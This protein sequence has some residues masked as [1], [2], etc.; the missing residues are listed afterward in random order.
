MSAFWTFF[1]I[2]TAAY[3]V[4]YA[5][6]I[7][8]DLHR[9]GKAGRHTSGQVFV[10]EDGSPVEATRSVEQT[11]GGFRVSGEEEKL[12]AILSA[13]LNPSSSPAPAGE[14]KEEEVSAPRLDAH[15]AVIAEVRRKIESVKEGMEEIEPEQS[16]ELLSGMMQ[17]ALLHG[18]PPV[19]IDKR[20]VEPGKE[21]A[22]GT[23]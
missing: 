12:S 7:S 10:L 14:K 18:R 17:S 1:A 9:Q 3:A 8:G 20:V 6:V 22:D 19:D 13:A 15:G 11:D 16:T 5:V 23:V 2:L 21:E 4:Y